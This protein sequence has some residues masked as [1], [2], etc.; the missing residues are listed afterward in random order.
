L[1]Q[2]TWRICVLHGN[3]H[4]GNV[5]CDARGI[6]ALLD[7]ENSALGD[8]RWDVASV[9]DSLYSHYE[10]GLADRF[11][12][13]YASQAA[14]PLAHLPFWQALVALQRW[15]VGSWAQQAADPGLLESQVKLWS[16]QAWRALTRLRYA[17]K[18]A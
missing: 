14:V 8:P 4:L 13:V 18:S 6:T 12:A 3:L 1:L 7:W 16:E 2:R 5:L 11:C 9:A 17:K 10:A 15:T